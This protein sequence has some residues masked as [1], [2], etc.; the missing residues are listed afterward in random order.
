MSCET[1]RIVVAEL[2]AWLRSGVR[3]RTTET[4]IFI[5]LFQHPKKRDTIWKLRLMF[6]SGKAATIQ[7]AAQGSASDSKDSSGL[8]EISP[9]PFQRLLGVQRLESAQRDPKALYHLHRI[10]RDACA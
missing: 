2:L 7:L 4:K 8:C 6:S 3:P 5:D 10:C 9:G 1:V